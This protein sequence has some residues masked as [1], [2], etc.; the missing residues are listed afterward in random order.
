MKTFKLFLLALIGFGIIGCASAQTKKGENDEK[1]GTKTTKTNGKPM[2]D[3]PIDK[4]ASDDIKVLAQGAYSSIEQPFVFAARSK[5]TYV[6]LQNLVENL[7]P[8]L[9]IDFT[10]AAVVAAFAGTKNTGGYSVSIKNTGDKFLIETVKPPADTMVTQ[11]ITAPFKVALVTLEENNS[12]NLQLSANWKNATQTYKI[13]SGAFESSGGFAGTR[14]KFD[15]EGT[16]SVLNFG[17]Y[18]TLIFNLAGKGAE[19]TKNLT[20]TASGLLTKEKVELARLDARNFSENP[21]PPLKVSGTISGGKLSLVLE[22]VPT[23]VADGF[24]LRGKIEAARV[25]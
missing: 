14:K 10:R 16:I 5:E 3:K 12:L 22:P 13:T 7:P 21:K 19:K 18:A 4:P 15:A 20:E 1:P 23:T 9:E 6:Q 25:G 17:D 11:V 24:Q 2:N 8:V